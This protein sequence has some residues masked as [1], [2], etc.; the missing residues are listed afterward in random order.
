MTSHKDRSN[1]SEDKI[2]E[3]PYLSALVPY[4]TLGLGILFGA[5]AAR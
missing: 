5:G 3:V 2:N 1:L 4:L